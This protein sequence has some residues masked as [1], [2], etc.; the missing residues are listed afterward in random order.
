MN[1]RHAIKFTTKNITKIRFGKTLHSVNL[2]GNG[3][4]DCILQTM[5]CGFYV[6]RKN[7]SNIV[8]LRAK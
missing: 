7:S 1:N 4:H 5:L 6:L 3:K 2:G 8:K